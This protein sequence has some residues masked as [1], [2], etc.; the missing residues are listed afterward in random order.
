MGT[1]TFFHIYDWKKND[2][3]LYFPIYTTGIKFKGNDIYGQQIYINSKDYNV[4]EVERKGTWNGDYLIADT[5]SSGLN[6]IILTIQTQFAKK[7]W[8]EERL[9]RRLNWITANYYITYGNYKR[10]IYYNF[11][12]DFI[13]NEAFFHQDILGNLSIENIPILSNNPNQNIIACEA[14]NWNNNYFF[15]S[16]NINDK[17]FDNGNWFKG[18]WLFYVWQDGSILKV[19]KRKIWEVDFNDIEKTFY[20]DNFFIR[21]FSEKKWAGNINLWK[22]YPRFGLGITKWKIEKDDK[23]LADI[24]AINGLKNVQLET[25]YQN[26]KIIKKAFNPKWLFDISK[27]SMGDRKSVV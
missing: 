8:T 14:S 19:D 27:S 24:E 18:S 1:K 9:A 7:W 20:F 23:I 11:Q 25:F 13:N 15:N 2:L 16:L 6:N 10:Y 17:N 26:T 21:A 4:I 3:K 5:S 22:D 12:L